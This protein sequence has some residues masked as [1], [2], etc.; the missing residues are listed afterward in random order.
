[1]KNKIYVKLH[2]DKCKLESFGNWIDLR[3]S[4]N[5]EL[6]KFESKLID[7]GV[8]MK[9]PKYYQGN[10]VPRSGT[11]KN[12]KMLQT[13]HYGVV[14]GPTKTTS[15][16]SGNNDRWKFS[17]LAIEDTNINEG[18]RICQFEIKPTMF[19]PFLV[20]LKWLFSSGVEIIYVEDLNS[21]DRGGFGS[22]GKK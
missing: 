11:Y 20:K 12:F 4:E 3:S 19:A 7:L 15:G 10:I 8:S 18:E 22:T 6:K 16:Y 9:L 1:M 17:A 5:V 21:D 13:N 14:D 2:N